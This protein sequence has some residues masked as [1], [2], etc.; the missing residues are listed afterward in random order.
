VDRPPRAEGLG[1]RGHRDVRDLRRHP[2]DG[3]QPH[4]L[5]GPGRLPGLGLPL[6][7]RPADRQRTRLSGSAGQLHGDAHLV[8]IPGGG[9]RAG[10]PPGLGASPAVD[11][12]E[13]RARGLRP[14]G[15]LRAGRFRQGLQLAQVPGEDRLL[16]SGRELQRAQARLDGR[17][18]RLSQRRRHLHRLHDARVPRQVHAV[19][20]PAAGR[21][22]VI[23]DDRYLRRPGPQNARHNEQDRQQGAEVADELTTGYEPKALQH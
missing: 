20:G 16:G 14:C 4:R 22:C 18:R 9:P 19:H 8:A 3:R 15:L 11:L 2:R 12:R 6:G 21:Q 10:D 5:H 13:D 1:R 17:P 23:R 7:G